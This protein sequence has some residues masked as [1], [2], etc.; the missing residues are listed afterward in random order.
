MNKKTVRM[1][2]QNH[3]VSGAADVLPS[4]DFERPYLNTGRLFGRV[5][6]GMVAVFWIKIRS[7][8]VNHGC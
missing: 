7:C 2:V 3:T 1:A 5:V 4:A 6:E 8:G